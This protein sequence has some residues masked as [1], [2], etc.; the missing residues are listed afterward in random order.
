M[1][2]PVMFPCARNRS[3]IAD[4]GKCLNSHPK[5]IVVIDWEWGADELGSH[6]AEEESD[7]TKA[8]HF[9]GLSIHKRFDKASPVFY[10]Y[11]ALG[12]HIPNGYVTLRKHSKRDMREFLVRTSR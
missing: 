8:A 10:K 1:A 12:K 4:R 3:H 9:N 6:R 2:T 7:D 11:C 5:E